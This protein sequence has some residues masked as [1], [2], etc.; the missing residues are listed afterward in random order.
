MTEPDMDELTHYVTIYFRQFMTREEAEAN[1]AWIADEKI[2]SSTS[3]AVLAA[4]REEW[5][6]TLKP[7]IRELLSNGR[8]AFLMSV[9]DRILREHGDEVFL[10][11]CPRC[12]AL[13]RTPRARQCSRCYFDWH[14]TEGEAGDISSTPA[15]SEDVP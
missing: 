9:R 2:D 4:I 5:V 11:H 14:G 3:A 15:G 13:A 8:N 6:S 7:E 1:C 12:N 10:N